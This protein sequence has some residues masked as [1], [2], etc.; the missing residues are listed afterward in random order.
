MRLIRFES[1][2]ALLDRETAW[3]DLWSRSAVAMPRA[4]AELIANWLRS[5]GGSVP[6][7]AIAVECDG[8]LVAA[9]PLIQRRLYNLLP[10]AS[11]P[12]NDWATCG[13]LLLDMDAPARSALDVMVAELRQH[14]PSIFWLNG[15]AFESGGWPALFQSAEDA[16][17]TTLCREHYR[18]GVIDASEN[19]ELAL[20][21]MNGKHRRNRVR[22]ARMLEQAGGSELRSYATELN[23]NLESLLESG[24]AVEDRSWKG[25]Q[26]TSVLRSPAARAFL[27]GEA[28]ALADNGLLELNFLDLGGQP[29]AFEYACRAKGT[30]YL[31]KIGFDA[32]YSKFGP[33]QQLV[34]RV[35]EQLHTDPQFTQF[36]FAGPL[37]EWSRPW[38][39]RSY[40]VGRVVMAGNGLIDRF[41]CRAY[42]RW[43]PRL[44]G[45]LARWCQPNGTP[46]PSAPDTSSNKSYQPVEK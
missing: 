25:H 1:L 24:Y 32:D 8:C 15:V 14:R 17:M 19:W 4:R 28:R 7:R 21:R 20:S 36:D 39:T 43:Y 41:T 5:F 23:G 46:T 37:V 44:K 31:M 6:F 30:H 12:E 2:Q 45:A 10:V 34:F 38:I 18:I 33:G 16:G 3:N 29:I 13:D 9:L 11:L 40:P 42:E 27:A 22:N 26:G 35:L